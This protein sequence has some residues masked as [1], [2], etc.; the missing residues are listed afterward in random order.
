MC[1]WKLTADRERVSADEG[2][3]GFCLRECEC[4]GQA[5]WTRWTRWTPATSSTPGTGDNLLVSINNSKGTFNNSNSK[6]PVEG[7]QCW[8]FTLTICFQLTP[9]HVCHF[10]DIQ[11]YCCGFLF[12]LSCC[13]VCVV[14]ADESSD[15]AHNSSVFH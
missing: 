7:S 15:C 10:H 2:P 8:T 9:S 3:T 14:V 13:V 4:G 1:R 5:R 11:Y 12:C 6:R